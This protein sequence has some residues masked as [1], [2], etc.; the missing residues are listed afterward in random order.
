MSVL[1]DQDLAFLDAVRRI[2]DEIAAPN[3]DDVDRKARF[4]LETLE[5][6]REL[7]A[8]SAFVPLELGG[9]GIS[10]EAV[11]RACYELGRG[12][13][14]SGMVFAMHQAQV[15]SIV[16]HIDGSGFFEEYLGDL[17]AGQRLI[18]SA[19]S[20]VGT[21][22]DMGRSIAG[23]ERDPDGLCRL[24]KQ[25]TT[26]SYGAHADDFLVTVRRTS[27]AEPGDQV[28]VLVRGEQATL[29]PTSGWDPLG[30]RG[31]CSPGYRVRG[32]VPSEQVVP[33]PFSQIAAETMVPIS[34]VVWS[35]LWLGI[36]TDAFDRARAYVREAA[37][38][39]PGTELPAG[40]R[41]SQLM[42]ELSLLRAEVDSGLR[43]FVEAS[44]EAGREYLTTV[45]AAVRFNNLKLAAS[46]QA[47]RVCQGALG[48]AGIAGYRNDT[49]YSVGRH[50]RDS[51]SGAVMI[52]N[53]RI[54]RTNASLIL[55]AKDV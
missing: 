46:E 38:Q 2:A 18:A 5:A 39:K 20:E 4:P 13:G 15:A 24:D 28:L 26:L 53:E 36:A 16:R 52:A 40:L 22:G 9:G 32:E 8:L 48:V 41:L 7:G 43:V 17:A 1:V 33:A 37:R 30:M 51:L 50:L 19:T 55:I 6:L 12:C 25:A 29:E 49:P 10:F 3:A 42:S 27:E 14:A 23:L 47:P 11:A 31:T 35:Q 45:A 34:H 44:D 21:G 54:H